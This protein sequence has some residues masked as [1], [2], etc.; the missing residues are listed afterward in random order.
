MLDAFTRKGPQPNGTCFRCQGNHWVG[1]FPMEQVEWQ[2]PRAN[3]AK[4]S[5]S[6]C[7]L[8]YQTSRKRVFLLKSHG[9]LGKILL[10]L[11]DVVQNYLE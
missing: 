11:V 6:L 3:I 1:D 2:M 8:V 9:V 7:F 4:Y 5:T 10:N